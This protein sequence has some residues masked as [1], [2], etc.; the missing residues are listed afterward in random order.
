MKRAVN[1]SFFVFFLFFLRL[2]FPKRAQMAHSGDVESALGAP[3]S[4]SGCH[5]RCK[6]AR[7]ICKRVRVSGH[8]AHV[9]TTGNPTRGVLPLFFFFF[10]KFLFLFFGA[11]LEVFPLMLQAHVLKVTQVFQKI[12]GKDRNQERRKSDAVTRIKDFFFFAYP[13]YE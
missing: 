4:R 8:A 6:S 5:F 13:P 1:G 7:N 11:S 10:F 2:F 3:G 12:G 9:Q